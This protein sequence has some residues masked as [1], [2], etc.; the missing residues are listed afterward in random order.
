MSKYLKAYVEL[1]TIRYISLEIPQNQTK[2]LPSAGNNLDFLIFLF[3]TDCCSPKG[4]AIN[5]RI[6]EANPNLPCRDAKHSRGVFA[7]LVVASRRR[8]IEDA[9][10][11]AV[12]ALRAIT[13]PAFYGCLYYGCVRAHQRP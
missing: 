1:L 2:N 5:C 8:V 9:V 13:R 3:E 12:R 4:H 6:P 11:V 10:I 7:S